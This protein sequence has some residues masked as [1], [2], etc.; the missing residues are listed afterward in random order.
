MKPE[1]NE[2]L[3]VALGAS[4]GGLEPLETFFRHMP[5]D[6]G[7]GFV[8]IQHLAPDHATALP[9]LLARHTAMP[10]EEAKDHTQVVPD[11]VY[12]IPPN[13]TLTVHDGALHVSAP[14]EGRGVR[15]PI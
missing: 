5:S 11:H 3:I 14:A 7:F 2:F 4:A 12:V 13:A 15:T 6:A 10:V 8:I 1:D 9:H